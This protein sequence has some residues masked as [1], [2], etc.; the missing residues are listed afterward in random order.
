MLLKAWCIGKNVV[1]GGCTFI[2]PV[3]C[4]VDDNAYYNIYN[5]KK[6][7][8]LNFCMVNKVQGSSQKKIKEGLWF[9]DKAYLWY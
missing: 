3:Q 2:Q 1:K 4:L 9:W 8:T 6:F 5:K 7:F